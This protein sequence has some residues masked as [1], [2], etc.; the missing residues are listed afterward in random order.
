[1]SK[2]LLAAA[3][4]ALLSFTTGA[5]AQKQYA[6]GVTDTEIKIG[7]TMPYSGP[8]SGFSG[9][10]K[11]ASAYFAMVNERGGINGR[12]INLLSQ[13]DGYSPP[14]ALE[15]TRKMVEQDKVAFMFGTL[16]AANN[17]VIR[18][19][20]NDNKVPHL[21]FAATAHELGD[22][23]NYPWTLG[24]AASGT[25]EGRIY[26]KYILANKP[27]AR[28]G[29]LYQDDAFGRDYLKGVME[30]LGDK[31][32]TMVVATATYTPTDATID[33]QLTSLMAAKVDTLVEISI[34]KFTAQAIRI[35]HD[36]GWKPM[37][38]MAGASNT[39]GQTLKPAGFDKSVGM[40]SAQ[41]LKDPSD[42]A[43]KGDA[44][45]NDFRAFMRKYA[46]SGDPTDFY[47]A[48]GYSLAQTLAEVLK[49]C[50][51]NLT[52]ENIMK[53]ATSIKDMELPLLLPGIKVN[54]SPTNYHPITQM[55][56][57]RFDGANWQLFGK[58]ISGD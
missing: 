38:L 16:G 41:F 15:L 11:G 57:W 19:Y 24:F 33:S 8:A 54:T 7:Q 48:Y 56:M 58:V 14:K 17:T 52:R 5:Q 22:P 36:T 39:M 51:D 25:I 18:K 42:P 28:V 6:P 40:L 3:L 9:I 21:F 37:Q 55:M 26:G 29:I 31:A 1:M 4:A 27:N 50:G 32:K 47:Y 20:L 12:K 44:G 13:D 49:R 30:G 53:Q 2:H 10:G 35:A 23:Q 34:P 45:M 43:W 46:P